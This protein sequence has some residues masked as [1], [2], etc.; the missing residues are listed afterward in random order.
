MALFR[1][2]VAETITYWEVWDGK[3]NRID[4][5]ERN[6]KCVERLAEGKPV[7]KVIDEF[8]PMSPVEEILYL[9]GNLLLLDKE[10]SD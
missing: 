2:K 3:G 7:I 4:Y 1:R 8:T 6:G 9:K 10:D 5:V